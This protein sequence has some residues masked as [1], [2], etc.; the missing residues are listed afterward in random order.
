MDK[1]EIFLKKEVIVTGATG[2]LGKFIAKRAVEENDISHVYCEYRNQEKFKNIFSSSTSKVIQVKSL[3]QPMHKYSFLVEELCKNKPNELVCILTSFTIEPI[4]KIGYFND[5]DIRMNIQTN[6]ENSI[7]LLNKLIM[8]NKLNGGNLRLINIDSGAAYKAIKGWSLYCSAKAYINM[9]LK[10]LCL[11]YPE[12]KAVTYDPG[13]MDT[14][15]QEIIRACNKDK[16]E[17]VDEFQEYFNQGA[18]NR[19]EDVA[20]D[21]WNRFVKGWTEGGFEARY[22][23]SE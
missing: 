4:E 14:K 19:P 11:E 2:G 8:F 18:L 10:T 6:I 3:Y 21:I 23:D 17:R 22:S 5:G 13:V 7:S 16:F 20:N 12:I 15:M 1:D 9:F